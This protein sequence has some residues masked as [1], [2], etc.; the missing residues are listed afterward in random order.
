M[1]CTVFFIHYIYV[2][3]FFQLAKKY[4]VHA[5]E[6]VKMYLS[7]LTVQ[8]NNCK[9]PPP[10]LTLYT[11][12]NTAVSWCAPAQRALY[13]PHD[14]WILN[15][16]YPIY[17]SNTAVSWCAPAQRAVYTPQCFWILWTPPNLIPAPVIRQFHGVLVDLRRG[18]FTPQCFWIL[19][20]IL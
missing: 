13:T 8:Y 17:P 15:S 4:C 10:P 3:L 12:Y 6:H 9:H 11:L 16:S 14:F 18:L 1:Q 19:N 2:L 7:H 20:Y 5:S